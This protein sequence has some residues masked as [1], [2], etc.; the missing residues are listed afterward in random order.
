VD[1]DILG[2][3]YE[4]WLGHFWRTTFD[5][6]EEKLNQP[7]YCITGAVEEKGMIEPL[8][9]PQEK[10]ILMSPIKWITAEKGHVFNRNPEHYTRILKKR[11]GYETE[12]IHD[13]TMLFDG[14]LLSPYCTRLRSKP[15]EFD[16]ID[17]VSKRMG[18]GRDPFL[19][20][21]LRLRLRSKY[22]VGV[23]E[24]YWLFLKPYALEKGHH[25]MRSFASCA[26]GLTKVPQEF[27]LEIV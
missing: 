19:K 4:Y 7:V 18:V 14:E 12:I 25:E 11:A 5:S 13:M 10:P 20:L 15:F 8:V 24:G 9:I 17:D 16:N 6:H 1:D 23:T 22:S 21:L 2:H 26:K 3:P 27:D